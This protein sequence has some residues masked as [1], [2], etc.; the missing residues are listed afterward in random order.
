[1]LLEGFLTI[2][3]PLSI[4]AM[5]AGVALGLFVGA[6]PGL[7]PTMAIA[8]ASP[9]TFFLAPQVGFPF[10][11]GIFKGSYYGGA[12]PAI[13]FNTPGTA[14]SAATCIDGYALAKQGYSFKALQ[15]ALA[16]SVCGD[17]LSCLIVVFATIHLAPLA[18]ILWPPDFA[19]LFLFSLLM[20]AAVSG[21]S[22]AKGVL[23]A[24]I[25]LLV[26]SVGLD[27]IS[28][29]PRFTFG[30]VQ[31][32]GGI[33]LIPFMIG[34]FA[35]GE[36]IAKAGEGELPGAVAAE[37]V[38]R[39]V[40]LT[41]REFFASVPTIIRGVGVGTFL[42][43]LPGIGSETSSW[44][45][46]AIGKQFSRFRSKYGTG[47]LDGVA[48]VQSA[49][50]ATPPAALVPLVVFG[51][52]G[53][54]IAAVLLGVF[55]VHG[56]RPGP[57]MFEGN[58]AI[59]HMLFAALIVSNFVLLGLGAA[60]LPFA[61]RVP[62]IPN[63]IL[64]AVVIP[65]CFIG[66]YATNTNPFDLWITAFG[67]LLGYGMRRLDVPLPPLIIALI[68]GPKLETSLRQSLAMSH[69]N[70]QI[71]IERPIALGLLILTIVVVAGITLG[72]TT[73]WSVVKTKLSAKS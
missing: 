65:I 54:T 11:I 8:L 32:T 40:R 37:R 19:M 1:M 50:N 7:G 35:L 46:Y 12:I 3:T 33:E 71:F 64:L 24:A 43:V 20:I 27:P 42:G 51:I 29:A 61:R 57:A 9:F 30:S 59:L 31:L 56:L 69:G 60:T 49:D 2:F 55:Y 44:A 6:V 36:M 10:L 18:L 58:A 70:L 38:V 48:A 41:I 66:A 13:L 73:W 4:T 21:K 39:N 67:G 53:D 26:G 52:P 14:A 28:G 72:R 68:L 45:S 25:G 34:T 63:R 16:A 15:M 22:M 23:S 17:L 62:A 47:S 5:F